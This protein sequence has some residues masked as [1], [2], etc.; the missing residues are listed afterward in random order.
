MTTSGRRSPTSASTTLLSTMLSSTRRSLACGC[1]LSRRPVAKLSIART[2][3]PRASSRSINVEPTRPDPP[4]TKTFITR[5]SPSLFQVCARTRAYG[6]S[7][8]GRDRRDLRRVAQHAAIMRRAVM[9]H[10]VP[11]LQAEQTPNLA[12]EPARRFEIG[13]HGVAIQEWAVTRVPTA[14]DVVHEIMQFAREPFLQGHREPHLVASLGNSRGK[15]VPVGKLQQVLH[16]AAGELHIRRDGGKEFDERMIEQRHP[17]LKPMRH[18]HPVLD[19]QQR[20]QEA[21]EIEMRHLVERGFFLD[22]ILVVEDRP[23]VVEHLRLVEQR[24]IDLLDPVGRAVDK[25][26]IAL[27]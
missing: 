23:E 6:A 3:S 10:L 9:E 19:L 14:E 1:R 4:V 22:V 2:S 5:T 8:L 12:G 20:R 15:F 18:A 16:A 24:P 11:Q 17:A 26:E 13:E 27:L 7:A 21:L 25:P